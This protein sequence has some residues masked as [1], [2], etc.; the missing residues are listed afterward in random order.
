MKK[1][2]IIAVLAGEIWHDNSL[3]EIT[4]ERVDL[5][6]LTWQ[7]TLESFLVMS[8]SWSLL[9]DKKPDTTEAEAMKEYAVKNG[10]DEKSILTEKESKDTIGN[11]YYLKTCFLSPNKIT[12]LIVITSDFHIERVKYIFKFVLGNDISVKI[13]GS[14]TKN[15]KEFQKRQIVEKS[16]L[17]ETK[18]WFKNLKQGDLDAIKNFLGTLPGYSKKPKISREYLLKLTE[19]VKY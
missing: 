18:K 9:L 12:D 7:K 15:K 4:K 8:G 10:V 13:I 17:A 5:G 14:A 1:T 11:A 3:K 19:L 16:L 6:I 2:K